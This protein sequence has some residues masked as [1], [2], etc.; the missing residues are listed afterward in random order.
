ML[1]A[2]EAAEVSQKPSAG[3]PVKEEQKEK[4]IKIPEEEDIMYVPSKGAG[5]IRKGKRKITIPHEKIKRKVEDIRRAE[6]LKRLAPGEPVPEVPEITYFPREKEG[7]IEYEAPKE[8][9]FVIKPIELAT[10]GER[11]YVPKELETYGKKF[12]VKGL[13]KKFKR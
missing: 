5:F 2:K 1:E 10:Y 4:E 12:D 13:L 8:K 11:P 9:K 7:K 6:I 3:V